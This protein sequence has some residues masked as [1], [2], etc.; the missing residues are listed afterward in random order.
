M[1]T[2]DLIAL[3]ALW[4]INGAAVGFMVFVHWSNRR[5]IE[6]YARGIADA[7]VRAEAMR[8]HPSSHR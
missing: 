2:G 5:E 7:E 8:R 3:A 4:F 6:A 1:S